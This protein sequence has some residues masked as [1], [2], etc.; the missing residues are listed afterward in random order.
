MKELLDDLCGGNVNL[1]AAYARIANEDRAIVES[2]FPVEVPPAG[3][4][5][6]DLDA[7]AFGCQG[8]GDGKAD[9]G[10]GAGDEG[11]FAG[12]LEIHGDLS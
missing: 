4:E 6:S 1:V 9:A 10:G 5:R 8:A 7:G 3:E 11:A 2:S 12:E